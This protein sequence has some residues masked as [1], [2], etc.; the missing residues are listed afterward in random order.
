MT[1][2]VSIQYGTRS[3]NVCSWI[4]YVNAAD[5][6]AAYDLAVK[7]IKRR[8]YVARIFGGDSVMK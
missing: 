5:H 7:R 3:G 1:F 4:G 2:I 6:S 8:P